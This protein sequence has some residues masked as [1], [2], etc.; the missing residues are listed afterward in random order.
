MRRLT[1]PAWR[2]ALLALLTTT[3]GKGNI[4]DDASRCRLQSLFHHLHH[5]LFHSSSNFFSYYLFLPAFSY[6][7]MIIVSVY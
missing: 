1:R 7:G 3:E 4:S 5:H 6:L 2:L